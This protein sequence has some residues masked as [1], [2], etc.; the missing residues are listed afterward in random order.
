[1]PEQF[2]TERRGLESGRSNQNARKPIS[3]DRKAD[4]KYNADEQIDFYIGQDIGNDK[5][6]D[7]HDEE[8]EK[9]YRSP[10]PITAAADAE[11]ELRQNVPQHQTGGSKHAR[12]HNDDKEC[13][14]LSCQIHFR[15]VGKGAAFTVSAYPIGGTCEYRRAD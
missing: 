7:R 14:T 8:Q 4:E 10:P 11:D 9:P 12:A 3:A 1:M 6:A 15:R 5:D 2:G 13:V